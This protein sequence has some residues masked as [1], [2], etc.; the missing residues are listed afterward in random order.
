MTEVDLK[1]PQ[2][3]YAE[4]LGA[5]ATNPPTPRTGGF[6][7]SAF[8]GKYAVPACEMRI[9]AQFEELIRADAHVAWR[10]EPDADERREMRR[11]FIADVAIGHYNW[12]GK[13]CEEARRYHVGLR[14]LFHLLL[15][16]SHPKITR[17]ESDAA[18][19][20]DYDESLAAIE[21]ALG[22]PGAPAEKRTT[23][24]ETNGR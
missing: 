14:K 12:D 21:F 4:A 11:D 20:A 1:D 3:G 22:N 7:L 18:Y 6:P 2:P 17:A 16:R 15:K 5:E 9:K 10:S 13:V 8:G 24:A 23:G 19:T